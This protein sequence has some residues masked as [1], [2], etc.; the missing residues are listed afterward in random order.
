M[1]FF[2]FALSVWI[3]YFRHM[4]I[5][6]LFAIGLC[7]VLLSNQGIA[8]CEPFFGKLVI[9]EVVAGNDNVGTDEFG[10]ND[11]WVEIY[12][13]SDEAI[14]L[15][16]FFLSDNDGNETK[17]TFPNFELAANDVVVIWCDDQPEQGDFHAAF[18]LS[19]AGEEV[20]LYDPDTLTLDYV[21]YGSLPDDISVGRFP[22]GRGPFSI[23]I[24]TFN[25][26]NTNSVQPGLVINEY[27]S[28]NESTAADQWGA[29]E[30]W[31]E[32]YN[33]G[34]SPINLEGYFLSDKIGS[35]T[36]FVFPDTTLM[37]DNY[38]IIWCDMPGPT[39]PGSPDQP[40]SA[41]TTASPIACVD[42]AGPS[43]AMSAVRVP[44]VITRETARS[45]RSRS[46]MPCG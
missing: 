26:L 33:A 46:T 24:P 34:N 1:F 41:A 16:G 22:N 37:P 27:Q 13:A 25:E 30:D 9:N 28:V 29:F 6:K 20:G 19:G 7:L 4:K 43:P 3:A 40:S 35:P 32:L 15:G 10:E 23:L 42:T 38:L 21:R 44:A 8:Q 39:E 12:N 5:S 18:R 31:I 36:Q 11:D 14:N 17:F 45:T 2:S